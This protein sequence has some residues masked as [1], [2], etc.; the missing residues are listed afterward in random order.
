MR[1]R[2]IPA[3][4]TGVCRDAAGTVSVEFALLLPI[5]LT[6]FFGCFEA[7]NLL[8]ADLKVVDATETAADLVAQTQIGNVLQTADFNNFTSATEQ[9]LTPLPTAGATLQLAFASVTYNTGAAVIDWHYEVNGATPIGLAS[10]PANLGTNSSPDSV[11][12]VR[13][14]YAYASPIS[15]VL[16]KTY[17]LS[18]TAYNR[19]RYVACVPSFKNTN[20]ACP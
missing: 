10:I 16:K 17:N 6:L 15:Y 19:P 3:A 14:R 9:V 13:V 4:R 5:L 2:T 1:A 20:S 12:V 11:V 18:S 7:S 8:L